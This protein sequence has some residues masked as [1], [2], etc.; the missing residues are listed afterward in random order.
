[1]NILLRDPEGE[2]MGKDFIKFVIIE[3]LTRIT[4]YQGLFYL[5]KLPEK[6]RYK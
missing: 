3:P 1:L 2:E 6:R 5:E 4:S